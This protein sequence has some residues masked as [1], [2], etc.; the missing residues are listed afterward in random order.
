VYTGYNKD[1]ESIGKGFFVFEKGKRDGRPTKRS[2]GRG[3]TGRPPGDAQ[4]V[5]SSSEDDCSL[6]DGKAAPQ[7]LFLSPGPLPSSAS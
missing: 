3:K 5:K 4:S 7:K 1:M 2:K 6:L